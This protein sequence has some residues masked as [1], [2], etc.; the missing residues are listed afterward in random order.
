VKLR[1]L[2]LPAA[3][4]VLAFVGH[5]AEAAAPAPAKPQVVDA[6]GDALDKQGMHDILGVTFDTTKT[7]VVT[8]KVVNKRKVKITTYKPKDFVVTV[9]LSGAPTVAPGVTYYTGV[10]TACGDLHFQTSFSALDAGE[11]TTA[12]FAECGP[13]V[14]VAGVTINTFD[15]TPTVTKT[16]NSI[17]YTTPFSSLPKEIKL[18]GSFDTPYSFVA[19]TDPVFGFDTVTFGDKSTAIDYA[20]GT[21]FKLP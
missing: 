14:T 9:K 17:V 19:A 10:D 11:G 3:L 12:Y 5:G 8:T 16:A 13:D 20:E 15:I 21:G 6:P 18:G 2:A 1:L 7:A 4:S